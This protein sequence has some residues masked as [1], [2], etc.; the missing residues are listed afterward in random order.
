MNSDY[1]E[2]LKI[3]SQRQSAWSNKLPKHLDTRVSC[4]VKVHSKEVVIHIGPNG[5]E[6]LKREVL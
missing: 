2:K 4:Y 1:K 3:S 5:P 6:L